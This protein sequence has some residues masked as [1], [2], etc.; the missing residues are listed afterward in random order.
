MGSCVPFVFTWTSL[1]HLLSLAL[2]LALHSYEFLLNSLGF[3][4]PIALFLILR[5]H[6]LAINPFLS[7]FSLLWTCRSTF[8]LF[9]I[10]YCPWFVCL[11]LLVFFFFFFSFWAPLNSFTL[12]RPICLSHEPVTHYSCRLGLMSSLSIYQLFSIRVAGLLLST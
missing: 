7:L 2:F 10:I 1:T 8:S 11:L 4:G 12:S 5:T 9:Y 3:P 6:G